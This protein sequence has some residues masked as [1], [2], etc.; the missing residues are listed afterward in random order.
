MHAVS[1]PLCGKGRKTEFL[2]VPDSLG[3]TRETF[4]LVRCGECGMVYLN[5]RPSSDEMSKYYPEGYC[6]KERARG[7]AGL[8]R[9][10]VLRAEIGIISR[11]LPKPGRMLDV[12][13]GSGDYIGYFRE[14]GWEAYGVE[15]AGPAAEHASAVRGLAVHRGDIFSA[16]FPDGHFDLVAYFQVL[17]HVADPR[18]QI[19]ESFRILKPGGTLLVQVPNVESAQFRRHR[20]RWLHLSAPQHLSHFSPATLW[21][22][23]GSEGFEVKAERQFSIR[24][25][26]LV[27]AVSRR[28]E[29]LPCVFPGLGAGCGVRSKILFLLLTLGAIPRALAEARA[30]MGATLAVSAVKTACYKKITTSSYIDRCHS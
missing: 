8:Y 21:K 23:L 26:P 20:E 15:N 6:W 22:L 29:L 7:L 25:D 11:L 3:I 5:P 9:E 2:R 18:E 28:P 17:E 10:L 16:G 19:R 27:E 12:G 4:T 30:G 13:C 14:R 24:M 1:C